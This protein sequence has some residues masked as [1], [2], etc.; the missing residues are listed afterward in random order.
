M[1][2]MQNDNKTKHIIC[3]S[4]IDYSIAIHFE[5]EYNTYDKYG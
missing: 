3:S 4:D 5:Y 1:K 2:V